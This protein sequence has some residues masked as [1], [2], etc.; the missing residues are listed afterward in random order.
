MTSKSDWSILDSLLEGC[1]IIGPDW[2][3][4][5]LN[6][7]ADIHNQRSKNEL[8]GQRYMD[9]WPGI[10]DTEVFEK[11][12]QCL[13][14]RVAQQMEN[15]FVFPDGT[16]EWFNLSIQPIPEG[17]F[18]LSIKITE[19]K[20]A[21]EELRVSEQKFSILFEKAA[22]A[23]SLSRVSDGTILN[24]NEAFERA[25]GYKKKEVLGKTSLELGIY[26]DSEIRTG[27]LN[28]LKNEGSV[29]DLE[30]TLQNKSG[31]SRVFSVNLDLMNIGNDQFILTSTQDITDRKK[32]ELEIVHRL[33]NIQS[34]RKIDQAIAGSLDLGLTLSVILEQVKTQLNVDAVSILL[35]NPTTNVLEYT[36]GSGFRSKAIEKSRLRLG[37]GHGGRAAL[38]RRTV[39]V[40][41]LQESINN[42]VRASL[43]ADEGFVTYFATPLIAKGQIQGVLEVYHREPFIPDENWLEFLEVLAG[44]SAIA[45]DSANL[46]TELRRSN[47]QLFKAYDSTIEGWSHAL[48]LRDKETEGHTLRVT[49]MTLKL[50]RAAGIYEKE[51]VHVRRGA[52]LHD[53]GKMGV[54]DQILLKPGA[55]TDEE[56]VIMRK[57]TTFAFELLS[58]IEYL[59]P[60][61][62]IPYCHHEK[63]DGSGYPRGL[64]GEQIPLVARLFAVIDV[65]DALLSDR[66]YRQGWSKDKVIEHIKSLSGTHFDP[67][68]V[69]LFL[70]LINEIK[71]EEN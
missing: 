56:W 64:K 45:V 36:T 18:I 68:A 37:E 50:S 34:L 42:F 40:P 27:I 67:K 13:T 9:M 53:I 15:E 7:A 51:L 66:P 24:I 35:F 20:R 47:E 25:F 2:R 62:D 43:L 61:L 46:L 1:Q 17:V 41:H 65:W 3:Y 44:Q 22:F 29:R 26:P 52:L 55:L 21:V 39:S 11:I 14:K 10:E 70:Q 60:A 63:W 32:T 71:G 6:D 4:L 48:D 28:K 38:E 31:E 30:L 8:L 19:W 16:K 23:A 58:P 54:P 59:R 69:D 33:Q 5:Y 49:E 57:H 12:K